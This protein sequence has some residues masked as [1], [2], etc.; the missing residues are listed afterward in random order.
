MQLHK[1][2]RPILW[3]KTNQV[4]LISQMKKSILIWWLKN[5]K[6][7]KEQFLLLCDRV[8]FCRFV[9]ESLILL[10]CDKYSDSFCF[11]EIFFKFPFIIAHFLILNWVW[12]SAN[13]FICIKW[14][15]SEYLKWRIIIIIP[16]STRTGAFIW[17]CATLCNT[18]FTVKST[19]KRT[20]RCPRG[21]MVNAMNLLSGQQKLGKLPNTPSLA[22]QRRPV[23]TSHWWFFNSSSSMD[24]WGNLSNL[25]IPCVYFLLDHGIPVKYELDTFNT[26]YTGTTLC[27]PQNWLC[28][29]DA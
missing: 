16:W 11:I 21:V 24:T 26:P 15:L 3:K 4:F 12:C 8:W 9:A 2:F 28:R 6:V 1:N 23:Q 19:L 14:I 27:H 7:Y 17:I 25:W 5:T 13:T 10:L 20:G 22:E 29:C 18:L